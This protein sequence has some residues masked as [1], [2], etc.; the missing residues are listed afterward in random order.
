M[1]RREDLIGRVCDWILD[2]CSPFPQTVKWFASTQMG[3]HINSQ[4]VYVGVFTA[5]VKASE[6]GNTQGAGHV[7]SPKVQQ[8]PEVEFRAGTKSLSS[9]GFAD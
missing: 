3:H 1:R 4:A 6:E 5:K 8:C 7:Q 2:R 9:I